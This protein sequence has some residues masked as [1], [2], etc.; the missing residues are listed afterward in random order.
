M[1]DE[2]LY[3]VETRKKKTMQAA[4]R[5]G[6]GVNVR[7]NGMKATVTDKN[8]VTGLLKVEY[9]LDEKGHKTGTDGWYFL[10]QLTPIT[11][12][13]Q[14]DWNKGAAYARDSIIAHIISMMN[15]QEKDTSLQALLELIEDRYGSVCQP[16]KG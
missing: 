9:P 6:K 14:S 4:T 2:K 16:F 5:Q 12:E 10:N 7:V 11:Q 13:T 1:K 3:Y 8:E 15:G